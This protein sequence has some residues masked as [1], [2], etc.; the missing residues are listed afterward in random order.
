MHQWVDKRY[1]LL[2]RLI[3]GAPF[4]LRQ[5]FDILEMLFQL[6]ILGRVVPTCVNC[7]NIYAASLVYCPECGKINVPPLKPKHSYA[8]IPKKLPPQ[9]NNNS[10]IISQKSATKP[11]NK[12]DNMNMTLAISFATISLFCLIIAQNS[13]W[14]DL[15]VDMVDEDDEYARISIK[16]NL[17]ERDTITYYSVTENEETEI[18]NNDDLSNE[19]PGV[20]DVKENTAFLLK[21]AIVFCSISIAVGI[22]SVTGFPQFIGIGI[23]S[24]LFCIV[25]ILSLSIYFYSTFDPFADN[26]IAGENDD[27]DFSCTTISSSG[28][29]LD[30]EENSDCTID[31]E[32]WNFNISITYSLGFLLPIFSLIICLFP[33]YLFYNSYN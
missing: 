10:M 9:I 13:L 24:T 28:W 27:S 31:G 26:S 5:S 22:L 17:D 1:R 4:S 3:K 12:K 25:I 11:L 2:G 14:L 32:T 21:A 23:F 30:Y 8:V 18:M 16:D 33:L 19:Y 29:F 20:V 15:R 7:R 6:R